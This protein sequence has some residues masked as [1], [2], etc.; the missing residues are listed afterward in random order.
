[1]ME[2]KISSLPSPSFFFV[3][4]RLSPVEPGVPHLAVDL[5]AYLNLL[6]DMEM[7]SQV[8]NYLYLKIYLII[9]CQV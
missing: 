1:M 4:G 6:G 7:V 9:K 8:K 2:R 5:Q 3:L